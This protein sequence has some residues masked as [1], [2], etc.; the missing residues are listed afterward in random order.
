MRQASSCPQALRT[1]LMTCALKASRC[2]DSVAPQNFKTCYMRSCFGWNSG[3]MAGYQTYPVQFFPHVP[4]FHEFICFDIVR[5][6]GRVFLRLG[7]ELNGNNVMPWIAPGDHRFFIF[8]EILSMQHMRV[9]GP[10]VGPASG[11]QPPPGGPAGQPPPPPGPPPGVQQPAGVGAPVAQPME[12]GTA[13]SS[14]SP[15]PTAA[16]AA[17]ISTSPWAPQGSPGEIWD[18]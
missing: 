10:Q 5:E 17:Q 16:P 14:T 6:N 2:N 3:T 11:P 12:S 8:T 13:S 15:F 4:S 9:P 18:A 1:L 7:F